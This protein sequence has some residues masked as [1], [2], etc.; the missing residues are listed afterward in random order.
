[1]SSSESGTDDSQRLTEVTNQIP[2]YVKGA[3]KRKSRRKSNKKSKK[4]KNMKVKK[5]RKQSKKS[6]KTKKRHTKK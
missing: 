3:G 1:M 2:P 6:R 4:K 5:T